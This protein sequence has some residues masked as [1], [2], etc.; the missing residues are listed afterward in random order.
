MIGSSLQSARFLDALSG[1]NTGRPPCWF[2]RQA[3]RYLPEYR[4]IRKDCPLIELF[5][6]PEKIYTITKLP[7]DILDVDAAILF[8]D[9][10]IPCEALGFKVDY[11]EKLGPKITPELTTSAQI[12]STDIS[13]ISYVSEGI[14]KLIPDLSVPLIGFAGGPFTVATYMMGG[15]QKA[16]TH[17]Y[18]NPEDFHAIL[19]AIT[20]ITILYLREQVKAGVT[21]LQIFD[22][23]AGV[24]P[25]AYFETFIT[26]YLD[27]ILKGVRDLD[28]PVILF[29]RGSTLF[30]RELAAINPAAISFDWQLPLSEMR[31]IIP[32]HIAIQ[33]NLDP[34]LL[35][36]P[37]LVIEQ[38]VKK[39]LAEMEED[40]GFILNLGHGIAPDIPPES[41]KAIVKTLQLN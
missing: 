33:G 22:S 26:P 13:R 6:D 11:I 12:H 38:E 18:T 14:K 30:A 17:L 2:M 20:D 27:Q 9:I 29:C 36:A 10:L 34:D 37:I 39:I 32:P 41:L 31:R 28:V 3:G 40:P 19:Q 24:L 21:A 16:K 1:K 23:W 25:K 8:S 5:H 4:A 15:V 7:I 35:R